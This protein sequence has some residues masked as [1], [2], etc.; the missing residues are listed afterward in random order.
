MQRSDGADVD[1]VTKVN[2]YLLGKVFLSP[3]HGTVCFSGR[4]LFLHVQSCFY[5]QASFF[6]L[7]ALATYENFFCPNGM[8][9][10][11]I[12]RQCPCCCRC[13]G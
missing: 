7:L 8:V 2:S 6:R 1:H 3:F 11:T 4:S 12:S 9:S 13:F 5:L 10:Q